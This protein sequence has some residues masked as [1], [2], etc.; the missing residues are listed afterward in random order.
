[1]NCMRTPILV[2]LGALATI[3]TGLAQTAGGP[4]SN[5]STTGAGRVFAYQLVPG[6]TLRYKLTAHIKGTIPLL[7]TPTPIDDGV[8]SLVYAATPK[9]LLANGLADVEL[10]VES[11]DVE[12]EGLPVP[13]GLED[14][15]KVLN[16]TVTFSPTG[17]VKKITGGGP[18]PFGVSIPG[19]DPKRLY[20]LLF[21]VVFPTDPVKPGDTWPFKS[22]LLGGQ[23]AK[24]AFTATLLPPDQQNSDA[25]LARIK[26]DFALNVDQNFD[27]NHKPVADP[28][29]AHRVTKGKITGGGVLTFDAAAGRFTKGQLNIKATISDDLTGQPQTP[30]EPKSIASKVDAVVTLELQPDG[31]ATTASGKT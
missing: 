8:I 18:L 5:G 7:G 24:P 6:K 13:I 23:G 4:G 10:K 29:Q 3:G 19:V 16:Q 30:D 1:M 31:P 14:A 15:E 9:T 25:S 26:T 20:S 27:A 21:P 12:L 11:V 28:S 22:E 2:L 17:E